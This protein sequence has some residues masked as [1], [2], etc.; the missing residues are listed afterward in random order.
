M[1]RLDAPLAVLGP[2]DRAARVPTLS[3]P[4]T[5]CHS[6]PADSRAVRANWSRWRPSCSRWLPGRKGTG[7]PLIRGQ[8]VPRQAAQAAV[9]AGFI[10]AEEDCRGGLPS[11]PGAV[12]TLSNGCWRARMAA[13]LA[14]AADVSLP[15][16]VQLSS[17]PDCRRSRTNWRSEAASGSRLGDVLLVPHEPAAWTDAAKTH[18]REALADGRAPCPGRRWRGTDWRSPNCWHL[19]GT[20]AESATETTAACDV[21]TALGIRPVAPAA[22]RLEHEQPAAAATLCE[23]LAGVAQW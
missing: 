7:L 2:E 8:E 1:E 17:P 11:G 18:L 20:P 15:V 5:V 23:H 22:E 21:A 14:T 4:A 12:D 6:G 10:S 19:V 3:A 9:T 13:Q 16:D